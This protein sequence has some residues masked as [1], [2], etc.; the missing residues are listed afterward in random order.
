MDS[1]TKLINAYTKMFFI[2]VKKKNPKY[3]SVFK[4]MRLTIKFFFF[5]F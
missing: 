5:F 2:S 1:L 3:P 4:I